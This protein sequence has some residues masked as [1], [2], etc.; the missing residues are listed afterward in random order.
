[1]E[2]SGLGD[3]ERRKRGIFVESKTQIIY[4]KPQRGGTIRDMNEE[5]AA[6]NGAGESL[7]DASLQ[8]C[9]AYGAEMCRDKVIVAKSLFTRSSCQFSSPALQS[10]HATVPGPGP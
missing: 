5:D 1:M 6:P 3:K 7:V 2:T 4:P 10:R 9:R 8:G